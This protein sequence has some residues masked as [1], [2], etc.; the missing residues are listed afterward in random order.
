MAE[1]LATTKVDVNP[2][3][4]LPYGGSPTV[5]TSGPVD[6]PI[7]PLTG[8]AFKN[9]APTSTLG[10]GQGTSD[11]MNQQLYGSQYNIKRQDDIGRYTEY[12][13]PL[14]QDLDWDEIRARNQST[15]EQWGRG[16][17][18]AGVTTLGAV[19]E[20]TL[21][22]IAGLGELFTGGA[23]Y[24]NAV[25]NTVDKTNAWMQEYMPNYR[26][27]EE[28]NMSTSQKLLTANFWGET[29]A[30]G[31]GYSLGSIATMWL[32][33][34]GGIL[35][36]GISSG[37]KALGIYNAS[38]AVINGTALGTKLAQGVGLASRLKTAAMALEAG[39]MMSLAEASVESRETQKSTYDGMVEGWL[40]DNVGSSKSDIPSDVLKDFEKVSYAAGNTNFA[41]QMPVLMGTNLLMFG[42]QVAG[43]KGVSK[44]SKDVIFDAASSKAVNTLAQKGIVASSLQRLKPMFYNGLEETLQ[45][46]LQMGSGAFASTY[47]TDKYNNGGYGD[48]SKAFAAAGEAMQSK[49]GQ[50]SALVG[51]LT[52][53]IMGGG[54]SI[55]GKEYSNRK[56]QAQMLT[57]LVNQGI[58]DNTQRSL[59]N[60]DAS[61]AAATRMEGHLKDGNLKKFK[62]EQFKLIQYQALEAKNRGGLQLIMEKLEDAKG[63]SESEFMK[64]FG[65]PTEDAQGNIL[66]LKDSGDKSQ[67]AIIE[68]FK[69]KLVNFE[70]V[71]DSVT[72]QFPL[73]DKTR[74]LPRKLMSEEARKAEDKVYNH[75]ERLRTELILTGSEISDRV[76]RMEAIDQGMKSTLNNT[77]S[78]NWYKQKGLDTALEDQY[79]T[80]GEVDA[81]EF[82]ALTQYEETAAKLK[83]ISENL[84]TS[85][86][87]LVAEFNEQANDY[88]ALMGENNIA[89]DR[90]NKLSSNE[91]AQAQFQKELDIAE[92]EA[93]QN[94]IDK[95]ITESLKTATTKKE[96][97]DL[98]S[99][100]AS[101]EV[102]REYDKK[103][104]EFRDAEAVEFRKYMEEKPGETKQ[105]H[106][107][108]LEDLDKKDLTPSEIEGLNQ[109]IEV[110]AEETSEEVKEEVEPTEEDFREEDEKGIQKAFIAD[111]L[112]GIESVSEDGRSFMIEGEE[113]FNQ[114]TNP[115][116]AILRTKRGKMRGIRL[117]KKRNGQVD[118]IWGKDKMDVLAYVIL[119]TEQSKVDSNQGIP[120][121][122]ILESVEVVKEEVDLELISKQ[123]HG[124]KTSESINVEVHDLSLSL[125]AVL[126]SIDTLRTY[127]IQEAEATK[128]DLKNDPELKALNRKAKSLRIQISQRKRILNL[129]GEDSSPSSEQQLKAERKILDKI[130]DKEANITDIKSDIKSLESELEQYESDAARYKS[131]DDFESFKQAN[132]NAQAA[133]KLI[134]ESLAKLNKL[135]NSLSYYKSKLNKFKNEQEENNIDENGEQVESDPTEGVE[136][137]NDGRESEDTGEVV[138]EEGAAVEG[139]P[140]E[141]AAQ[142]AK[143]DEKAG[144]LEVKLHDEAFE[145]VLPDLTKATPAK[146]K[147]ASEAGNNA[148]EN[149]KELKA[150]IAE[151]EAL[152]ALVAIPSEESR[153]SFTNEEEE[154]R[155]AIQI[156]KN[157]NENN[158]T[159]Q[160]T[161]PGAPVQQGFIM[162]LPEGM[163]EEDMRGPV[164]ESPTQEGF[165]RPVVKPTAP[166]MITDVAGMPIKYKRNDVKN[167]KDPR[168]NIH[169]DDLIAKGENAGYEKY[170]FKLTNLRA[171]IDGRKIVEITI[172]ET[173][174]TFLFYKSTGT[175]TTADTKGLWAPIPGFAADEWFLKR[176][177]EGVDPKKNKYNVPFFK[178]VSEYLDKRETIDVETPT[179]PQQT[180]EVEAVSSL[181]NELELQGNS[182]FYKDT[183]EGEGGLY[184]EYATNKEA[185]EA[186]NALSK[187]PQ[188]TSNIRTIAYTPKGKTK[189]TYTIKGSKIYNQK[190]IEVFKEDSSDRN[191]IFANLAVREGRAVVVK[192]KDSDYI[193]NNKNQIISVATGK[194]M[195]WAENNGDRIAILSL[196]PT[197]Q[198]SEVKYW[199]D[200]RQVDLDELK[201]LEDKLNNN[202]EKLDN[203]NNEL[204]SK[205]S[206]E[207]RKEILDEMEGLQKQKLSEWEIIN[208][209]RQIE[210]T[211]SRIE[212][213]DAELAALEAPVAQQSSE[214][215]IEE[216]W[217]F[218]RED[219]ISNIEFLPH[220]KQEGRGLSKRYISQQDKDMSKEALD[221]KY[222]M[223]VSKMRIELGGPEVGIYMSPRESMQDMGGPFLSKE[224]ITDYINSFYDQKE[225][226]KPTQQSSEVNEGIENTDN[227][228][229]EIKAANTTKVVKIRDKWRVQVDSSDNPVMYPANTVD[230]KIIKVNKDLLLDP[231][232][233]NEIVTL[234]IIATDYYKSLGDETSESWKNIPIYYK[235]GN[236]YVGQ[237]TPFNPTRHNTKERQYIVDQLLA[238]NS[239][240]TKISNI[241]AGPRNINNTVDKNGEKVFRNPETTFGKNEVILGIVTKSVIRTGIVPGPI[242]EFLDQGDLPLITAAFN[243]EKSIENLGNGQIVAAIRPKNNPQR[244]ARITPLLTANLTE[245]HAGI[246]MDL[247]AKGEYD[248]VKEIVATSS[249][250]SDSN[251]FIR[252]DSYPDG[253]SSITYKSE[254]T[255]GL[256][257]IKDFYLKKALRGESY[258]FDDVKFKDG[259]VLNYKADRGEKVIDIKKDL[260]EFIKGKKYNVDNDL[261][262]LAGDYTSPLTDE[263][264]ESTATSPFGY[265]QYLF[266]DTELSGEKSILSTDVV[267][268][269]ESVFNN[270]EV[271]FDKVSVTDSKGESVIKKS[272][273]IAPAVVSRVD[274]TIQFE[275]IPDDEFDFDENPNDCN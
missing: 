164:E 125:S 69:K 51:F 230:G 40:S 265:Q 226:N 227:T 176:M 138:E 29:V 204:R 272:D 97:I 180:S 1:A 133:E 58:F 205:P 23:Y 231:N 275:D 45:E 171:N 268:I 218:E 102:Q 175:G 129:R 258:K 43:F 271:T 211:K 72:K 274:D 110:L 54:Q 252:I 87:T 62:D 172:P 19:A 61:S 28:Q 57:D 198:T 50:E 34:G 106:L 146:L 76:R 154:T 194:I 68:G 260:T 31:L 157:S 73:A 263:V 158:N 206:K 38:K 250:P 100:S 183:E 160:Q 134:E 80:P 244:D 267:K 224:Q 53:M 200:Y 112:A 114:E 153:E 159:E 128:E 88:L 147:K 247:L 246:V 37:A 30:G 261:I 4:G 150:I 27:K 111:N 155:K 123:P 131:Q 143:L 94:R 126:E 251:K 18:K 184:E 122:E 241:M 124:A 24:D 46:S 16:L 195:K 161:V 179:A 78:D 33:G 255:G 91:Y 192:Y 264:Y 213:A 44:V 13:V 189:Q 118:V 5:E 9:S 156:T 201:S 15:A 186:F 270:P 77:T 174:E 71:H 67:D 17:A 136:G 20:N 249:E 178:K 55:V 117:T 113:Y 199:K 105:Q 169:I 48:M 177:H 253:S 193:V 101:P 63:L 81:S 49:E 60:A 99:D 254:A 132:R 266:S 92:A 167:N 107:K 10:G 12:G 6:V 269:G 196:A 216:D 221:E 142:I 64:Q 120:I 232:I 259:N 121:E 119:N 25:G 197:Q 181:G 66:T 217:T 203:L 79:K 11:I 239:V 237:L 137:Q 165:I 170:N 115:L 234:E 223:W 202:K 86:P 56:Q 2:L 233:K 228:E 256:V 240:T 168:Y 21:G 65:Y 135:E 212:K 82:D 116:D 83:R 36:K 7:N 140:D 215:E 235:V 90:Y 93:K 219:A 103:L 245:S 187:Q 3:T 109:A 84:K 95:Q 151:I 222:G 85:N 238:G 173:G 41:I 14:G 214:V 185:K 257:R 52:G 273:I 248:K 149:S 209:K 145:Q 108:R 39:A 130:Y 220:S 59:Q 74:G 98:D 162:G 89:I 35:T 242:D 139:I 207:R 262:N 26:T 141:V 182:I 225:K 236:E 148:V 229:L 243:A 70:K 96:L 144:E 210:A 191:K 32:T 47:H 75:Q 190:G 22:V 152:E 8:V 163:T 208:V 42:K 166:V 188:Q 127:Y 104:A